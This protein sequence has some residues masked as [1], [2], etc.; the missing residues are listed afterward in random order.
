MLLLEL[1]TGRHDVYCLGTCLLHDR[2]VMIGSSLALL[3]TTSGWPSAPNQ[4]IWALPQSWTF[5][6]YDWEQ[7]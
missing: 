2:V 5:V 4:L 1:V 7:V 3:C 6:P